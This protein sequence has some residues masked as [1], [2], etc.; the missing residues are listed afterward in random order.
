MADEALHKETAAANAPEVEH[1]IS[2]KQP[3]PEKDAAA[4]VPQTTTTAVNGNGNF[5]VEVADGVPR[6]QGWIY[7]SYFGLWWYASPQT[8]LM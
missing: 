2:E 8:Q 5:D 7:R 3:V 1:P 4:T 6:P